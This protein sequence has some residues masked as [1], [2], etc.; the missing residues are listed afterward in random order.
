MIATSRVRRYDHCQDLLQTSY[1]F[2]V[3]NTCTQT[4]HIASAESHR[5]NLFLL[6]LLRLMRTTTFCC[7]S[8]VIV[9][10]SIRF[11]YDG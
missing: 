8:L 5:H 11:L 6:S 10:V 9:A 3:G 7:F 1:V 2:P 4:F